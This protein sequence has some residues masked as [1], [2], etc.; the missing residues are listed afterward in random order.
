MSPLDLK[1]CWADFLGTVSLL[2]DSLRVQEDIRFIKISKPLKLECITYLNV[3][4]LLFPLKHYHSL[5]LDHP[6]PPPTSSRWDSPTSGSCK[7]FG[8][9]FSAPFGDNEN[10]HH[11]EFL[12]E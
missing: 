7:I 2:P 11:L 1:V 4:L 5:Q 12:G 9:T 10:S 6:Q 8:A 3:S